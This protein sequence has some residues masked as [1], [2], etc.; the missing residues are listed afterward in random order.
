MSEEKS[1][2]KKLVEGHRKDLE[3]ILP[4]HIN[5]E[6]FI[7]S[8]ILCIYNNPALQKCT[9]ESLVEAIYSAAEL[10]LDFI[11][12]RGHAYLVPFGNK[13][14]FMPGYRGLT[15]LALRGGS[16]LKVFTR[17]VYEG[18]GFTLTY[19]TQER[20][21][22][23]PNLDPSKRGEITGAYSVA[24]LRNGETIFEYMIVDELESVRK[25]SKMANKG[26]WAD[27]KPEMYKKTVERRLFKHLPTSPDA[28]AQERIDKAIDL[29]NKA[30]GLIQEAEDDPAI[31][32]VP[33]EPV[34]LNAD[35]PLTEEQI[36]QLKYR[37]GGNDKILME[38]IRNFKVDSPGAIKQQD[39][40]DALDYIEAQKETQAANAQT[41]M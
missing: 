23:I 36:E 13:A 37:A 29:D 24:A 38:L 1:Q 15:D 9:K 8:A 28:Q 26:A 27:H 21:V 10:G 22:H 31:N 19:G 6:R 5:L 30:V 3:G 12:T 40:S 41:E 11:P 34:I 14:T 7:K 16:V 32:D 18:D 4:S 2:I 17:L 35:Q 20:I 33:E 39:F 25:T